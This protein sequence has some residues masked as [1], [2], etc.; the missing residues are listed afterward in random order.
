MSNINSPVFRGCLCLFE[1]AKTPFHFFRL[2]FKKGFL[3]LNMVGWL[4]EVILLMV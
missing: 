1:L 3:S 4:I 2:D